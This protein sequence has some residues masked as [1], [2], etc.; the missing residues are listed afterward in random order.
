[1]SKTIVNVQFLDHC[2]SRH[3]PVHYNFIA[4]LPNKYGMLKLPLKLLTP[5]N[6]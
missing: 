2:I 3:S 1:M 4:C 6:S 5:T